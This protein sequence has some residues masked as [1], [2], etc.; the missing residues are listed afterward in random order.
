MEEFMIQ[1]RSI[2]GLLIIG[3]SLM[4][5]SNSQFLKGMNLAVNE[6]NSENYVDLSAEI[7]MGNIS[8]AGLSLP[9]YDPHSNLEIGQVGLGTAADGKQQITLSL[10]ATSVL[11]GDPTLGATL[12]NGRP[13]PSAVGAPT[14]TLMGIQVLNYSRVYIGGDLKSTIYVGVALAIQ[15]LDSVTGSIGSANLFFAETFN[16]NLSGVAGIFSSA[17]AH[18][19]GIAVFAKYTAPTAAIAAP[20]AAVAPPATP[21]V[22]APDAQYYAAPRILAQKTVATTAAAS[23]LSVSGVSANANTIENDGMGQKGEQKVYNYF[24]GKKRSV[25]PH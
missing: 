15:A 6:R 7:D 17:T 25:R 9:I 5:C 2:I 13:I 18:Q 10:N 12:P 24:Y 20:V 4:A 21:V 19:N 3:Q 16:S 8:L 11:S 1:A 14:N 22:N 23:T